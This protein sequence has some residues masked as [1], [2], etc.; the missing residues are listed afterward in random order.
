LKQVCRHLRRVKGWGLICWRPA[1][2]MDLPWSTTS[3]W[4]TVRRVTGAANNSFINRLGSVGL[5]IVHF[6]QKFPWR[7]S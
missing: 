1:P 4:H 3:Q 5:K 6:S 2:R 7:W